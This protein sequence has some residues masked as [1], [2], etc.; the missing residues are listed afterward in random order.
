M[1]KIKTTMTS[2][3]V[4]GHALAAC[5][6]QKN[7]WRITIEPEQSRL[8]ALDVSGILHWTGGEPTD[9]GLNTLKKNFVSGCFSSDKFSLD[10]GLFKIERTLVWRRSL[11]QTEHMP[12]CVLKKNILAQWCLRSFILASISIKLADDKY[13]NV[14]STYGFAVRARSPRVWEVHGPRTRTHTH[15]HHGSLWNPA[16]VDDT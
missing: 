16:G 5:S 11:N 12:L 10:V 3:D 13:S 7:S 1:I 15:R 14:W 2:W 8:D 9:F 6:S 4:S